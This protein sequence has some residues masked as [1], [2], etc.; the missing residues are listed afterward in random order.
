[1]D[2]YDRFKDKLNDHAKWVDQQNPQSEGTWDRLVDHMDRNITLCA[3]I[4]DLCARTQNP[5]MRTVQRDANGNPVELGARTDGWV[6]PATEGYYP[7]PGQTDN[8]AFVGDEGFVR[9]G[10]RRGEYRG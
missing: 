4:D 5:Y 6:D 10:R 7:N 1:M 3:R 9:Q 8:P 2:F